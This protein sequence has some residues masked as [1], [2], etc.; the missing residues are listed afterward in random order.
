MDHPSY[1]TREQWG[2]KPPLGV[3]P[4]RTPVMSYVHHSASAQ[5]GAAGVR[6][7]QAYHMRRKAQGGKG[8][9]DI[10]YSWLFDTDGTIFEGRGWGVTHGANYGMDNSTSHSF[11]M[12][13]N[14]QTMAPSFD[15]LES[16]SRMLAYGRF[17]GHST[18]LVFGHRDEF[19]SSTSCPG[20][21]LYALLP[22]IR[23]RVTQI[24]GPALP[25]PPPPTPTAKEDEMVVV[26]SESGS[27]V[28]LFENGSSMLIKSNKDL[29]AF[30]SVLKSVGPV[31]VDQMALISA[32]RLD[33]DNE[34]DG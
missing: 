5:H 10:A 16:L 28:I 13:G 9:R 29:T 12:L 17:A 31:T 4:M 11:C 20:D 33:L 3:T 24:L 32:E 6:D 34:V 15:A 26:Q 2:A 30:R 1:V 22:N 14:F 25:T 27:A 21:K 18:T 8:M 19:D 23:K 7:I